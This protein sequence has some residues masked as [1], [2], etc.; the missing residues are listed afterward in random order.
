M[1][2]QRVFRTFKRFTAWNV[3]FPGNA[4]STDTTYTWVES[5]TGVNNPAWRSQVRRHVSATTAFNAQL[6]NV[7]YSP[8]TYELKQFY[9]TSPNWR[10]A[11]GQG[12]VLATSFPIPGSFGP[13]S[14]ATIDSIALG[15]FYGKIREVQSAFQGGT[16]LGELAETLRMIKHPAMALR[17]GIDHYVRTAKRRARRERSDRR[18]NSVLRDTWLEY[19][20][21]WGPL[22]GDVQD[23]YGILRQKGPAFREGEVIPVYTKADQSVFAQGETFDYPIESTIHAYIQ[24][25]RVDSVKYYGAVKGYPYGR[26]LVDGTLWGLNTSNWIP[27]IYNLIPYSFLVDYFTNLGDVIDAWSM[28]TTNLAWASKTTRSIISSTRGPIKLIPGSNVTSFNCDSGKLSI[29][30][31]LINRQNLGTSLPYPNLVWRLPGTATKWVNVAALA[32]LRTLGGV[33][34]RG[35]GL[36][37]SYLKPL[38]Y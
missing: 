18:R 38:T 11:F 3:P 15:Q 30:L 25:K 20:Y 10:T 9:V 7:E 17:Q 8:A 2:K 21:G 24:N 16:F 35:R 31:K 33:L 1:I 12:L 19:S 29:S 26:E 23:A 4:S 22:I 6:Y 5:K 27:T 32:S 28:C 13:P 34:G 36:T 37:D 14:T